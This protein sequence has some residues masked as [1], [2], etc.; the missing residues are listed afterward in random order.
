MQ[1]S[2]LMAHSSQATKWR[3]GRNNICTWVRLHFRQVTPSVIV[4]FPFSALLCLLTDSLYS[5]FYLSCHNT[6]WRVYKC[7]VHYLLLFFIKPKIDET[8]SATYTFHDIYQWHLYIC[9]FPRQL[10]V[11]SIQDAAQVSPSMTTTHDT[12]P[13]HL[14]MASIH[15]TFSMTLCASCFPWHSKAVCM[16]ET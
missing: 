6:K 10:S 4:R 13:R 14:S 12:F 9:C 2:M 1:S 7:D 15:G 16:S 11:T 5:S 8:R 3:Q